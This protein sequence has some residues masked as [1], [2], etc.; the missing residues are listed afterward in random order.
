MSIAR[1]L[2]RLCLAAAAGCHA[3]AA[4]AASNIV[5]LL[6][7][8]LG[9]KDVGF[10][11]GTVAT[12]H[13]DRLAGGGAVLNALY[14]PPHS[15]QT[16]AAMLTG[17]HPM[18][19]GLQTMSI[20]PANRFGLPKHERTLAEM[21]KEAGYATAY[22]G[23]WQLGHA[24]PEFWPT[25]RGF[26]YF[27]GS[28]PAPDAVPRQATPWRRNESPVPMGSGTD[29]TGLLA[30]DAIR[31]IERHDRR[32][33]LF[34]LV[35][36]PTPASGE[37]PSPIAAQFRQIAEPGRRT[38]AASVAALDRAVGDVVAALAKAGL[39]DNTLIVFHSDN[40]GSLP[41]RE[42]TGDADAADFGADNGRYRGGKG[43]L[44]EGGVRVAGLLSWP[45]R[46][47]PGT[48]AA[49]F[50]HVTDLAATILRAAEV[51]P[52]PSVALD[53]VDFLPSI[54]DDQPVPRRQMLIHI[55][56]FR[57]A[58]RM[59][60]WKLVV[61]SALPG[62]VELFDIGRDP[63]EAE[64]VADKYPDRVKELMAALTN[65]AYEMAP[66]LYLEEIAAAESGRRPIVWRQNPTVR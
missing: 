64:N 54:A 33:P 6:A 53:G 12:P 38:H 21:L 46:I 60:D 48:T 40:G 2:A 28:L 63:E 58:F 17:R 41:T 5:Y 39:L 1:A 7:D 30:R 35:A 55:E 47:R 27:Y 15:S 62:K 11:G 9:W 59:N 56:A 14:A 3:L 20:V 51:T 19:Y 42:P 26:E 65:A 57:G 50:L 43:S 61:H 13:L 4:A 37:A 24:R 49:H 10:H 16:H 45:G 66:S 52:P 44:Y 22:L 36:F 31:V 18:R 23:K 25:R 32:R 34:M 8:D 29:A